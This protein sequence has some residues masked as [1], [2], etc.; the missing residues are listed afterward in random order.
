MIESRTII[1]E[2]KTFVGGFDTSKEAAAALKV[3]P[4][5]LSSTL[6]G[7]VNVIPEKILKKLG[8]K[9][10]LVYLPLKSAKN[11]PVKAAPVA[12]PVTTPDDIVAHQKKIDERARTTRRPVE[13]PVA[14]SV[15]A[16][17]EE[18]VINVREG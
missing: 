1:K 18:T 14:L 3:T 15:P 4:A 12:L 8:Y 7:K 11:V 2:L 16:Q 10:A 17:A 5:Q 9:S 13:Q 6:N